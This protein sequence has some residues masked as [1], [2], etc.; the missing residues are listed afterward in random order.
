MTKFK[1]V[2]RKGLF[3]VIRLSDDVMSYVVI[4]DSGRRSRREAEELKEA[5]Q[6]REALAEKASLKRK[7]VDTL[8]I[9]SMVIVV[10]VLYAFF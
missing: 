3:Y 8:A 4:P 9:L 2:T 7:A 1:V 6:I 10:A 5:L